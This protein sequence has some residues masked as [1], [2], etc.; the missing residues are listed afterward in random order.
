M[1]SLQ[2]TD[3]AAK[4]VAKSPSTRVSLD[5]IEAAI[6][7]EYFLNAHDAVERALD[8]GSPATHESLRVLTLC[9]IVM[10]NGFTVIGKAAP[11][12]PA[13]FNPQLGA[14]FARED[15]VRQLWPLMGYA[16]RD[17]LLAAA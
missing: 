2:M 7:R 11:A 1:D 17:R 10:R 14:K 4:A 9:V 15:A 16:L 13:N 8:H 6:E 5:D 3:E 12:D